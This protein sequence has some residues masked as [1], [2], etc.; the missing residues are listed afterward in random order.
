M[1]RRDTTALIKRL[2]KRVAEAKKKVPPEKLPEVLGIEDL[3]LLP[4]E[5]ELELEAEEVK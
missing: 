2:K 4:I 3:G 5:Q 1:A